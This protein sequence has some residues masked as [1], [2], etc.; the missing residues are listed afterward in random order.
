MATEDRIPTNLRTLLI[1]EALGQQ[2]DPMSPSDIGRLIGLPKQTVHRLCNTLVA[3]GF[4][5]RDERNTGLRPG[6][7]AR[8]MS[9]GV[10]HASTS[11]IARRQ[12][13]MQ[14]AEDI[15]ETIN[16]VVPEDR[17]MAY[18]DRVETNW[19]FRIQLPVGSHVPFHC[20]ASGKTFLASLPKAER[21]RLVQVMALEQ[22]TQNTITD[23]DALMSELQRISKQ[24]HALDNEEFVD[25]MIALAV[26][27]LDRNGRYCASLAFHGPLQ[28]VSAEDALAMAPKLRAASERLTGTLFDSG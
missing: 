9:S 5:V 17:G 4:L 19:A 13:L 1:L 18:H 23:P 24:G 28:R 21:R 27:V 11:Y 2:S 14:L 8:M 10:L 20:T 26:P 16:F 25:G 6:R 7:R 15:G 3:E 22:V 12:V